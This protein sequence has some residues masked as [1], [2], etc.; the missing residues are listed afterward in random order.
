MQRTGAEQLTNSLPLLSSRS[1]IAT[2]GPKTN[3]VEMLGNLRKAG[4]NIGKERA[5]AGSEHDPNLTI[6]DNPSKSA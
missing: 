6:L 3:S 4:M 2:I 1:I 5:A